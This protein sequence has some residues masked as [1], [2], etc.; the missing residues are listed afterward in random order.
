MA[1]HYVFTTE[2]HIFPLV[3]KSRR[4]NWDISASA[5]DSV[6]FSGLTEDKKGNASESNVCK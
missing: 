5:D 1:S 4:K 2:G 6:P 3:W